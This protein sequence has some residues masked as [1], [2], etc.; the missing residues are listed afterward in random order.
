MVH[1]AVAPPV[2][3]T[4]LFNVLHAVLSHALLYTGFAMVQPT[5][6]HARI[7]IELREGKSFPALPAS[8]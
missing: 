8:F 1:L 4:D 5:V 3:G 6:G 7:E 2:I